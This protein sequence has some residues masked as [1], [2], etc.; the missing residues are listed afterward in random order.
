MSTELKALTRVVNASAT[1]DAKAGARYAEMVRLPA[2]QLTELLSAYAD[3]FGVS[4][5]ACEPADVAAYMGATVAKFPHKMDAIR[6]GLNRAAALA[7]VAGVSGLPVV[8]KYEKGRK[9]GT[10]PT[11]TVK[12]MPT[13][14]AEKL[15]AEH[16]EKA[17]RAARTAKQVKSEQEAS[18]AVKAAALAEH[19][20]THLALHAGTPLKALVEFDLSPFPTALVQALRD[21]CDAQLRQ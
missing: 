1:A 14:R 9:D 18:A 3:T 6:K 4:G 2:D 20:Q 15:V 10:R 19:A 11:F 16:Q 21:M 13:D 17:R 5:G 7:A 8:G 12:P